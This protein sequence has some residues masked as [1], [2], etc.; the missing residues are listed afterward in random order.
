MGLFK[1]ISD[2]NT[3]RYD[4]HVSNMEEK[5]LCPDCRGKGF[6]AY[7]PNEYYYS[8]VYECSGCNGSGSFTDWAETNAPI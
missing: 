7:A 4:R 2:W 5:G 3:A 6:N 8:N 1:A